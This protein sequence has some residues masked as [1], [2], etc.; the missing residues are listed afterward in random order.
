MQREKKHHLT[1]VK[2]G[3]RVAGH[4]F[5]RWKEG[6]LAWDQVAHQLGCTLDGMPT[7]YALLDEEAL[8]QIPASLTYQEAATLPLCLLHQ[9][10]LLKLVQRC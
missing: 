7:E 2:V 3:D 6:K 8:V 5:A 1:R 9:S 4:Y 10:D